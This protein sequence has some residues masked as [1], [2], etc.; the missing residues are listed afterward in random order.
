MNTPRGLSPVKRAAVG[1]RSEDLF[2]KDK[3]TSFNPANIPLPDTPS[4]ASRLLSPDNSRVG[5]TSFNMLAAGDAS[6]IG[7]CRPP[8]SLGHLEDSFD[9]QIEQIR[10]LTGR[11]ARISLAPPREEEE[12]F[13]SPTRPNRHWLAE[14]TLL[15]NSPRVDLMGSTNALSRV[16]P[17][18][19]IES[20]PTKATIPR[21]VSKTKRTFPASSSG[22]SL[23]SVGEERE[24]PCIGDAST[25]LPVSPAKMQ[26]LLQPQHMLQNEDLSLL[27]SDGHSIFLPRPISTVFESGRHRGQAARTSSRSPVKQGDVT[28][29]LKDVMAGMNKPKR[30][31]GGEMSFVDLLHEQ[32]QLDAVEE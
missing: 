23:A 28:L 5:S 24:I 7:D 8:T 6:L 1:P 10:P 2:E 9:L 12:R 14:S 30:Q 16:D 26:Y 22:Q 18:W 19:K 13:E 25:L 31:S 17:P 11:K 20:S 15:P 32:H 3:P 29:D 27:G 21:S 4:I